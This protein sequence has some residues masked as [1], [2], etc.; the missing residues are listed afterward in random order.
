MEQENKQLTAKE[1]RFCEEYM[2][3]L[4]GTQAA[5][6]AGYS[7]KSA[8]VIASQNLTKLNLRQ[9]IGEKLNEISLKADEV[10]KMLSDIAK[11]SL[12][13]FFTIRQIEHTPRILKPLTDLIRELEAEINFENDFAAAAELSEK[14][15]KTHQR[16]QKYRKRLLLKYR[17]ELKRN[18]SFSRIV[19]GPTIFIDHA[20]LDMVKLVKAKESGRIKSISYTPAGP[21][22]EMYA[23]DAALIALARMH[24]LFIDNVRHS[25]S[26]KIGKDLADETYE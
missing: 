15:L 1:K 26:I 14:E 7:S 24:G 21:K 19:D 22:V 12:N 6:R 3:D 10:T 2:I 16:D 25:G 20:E 4:N 23:A 9:F 13:D 17:L 11:S 18:P 5:I 8:K